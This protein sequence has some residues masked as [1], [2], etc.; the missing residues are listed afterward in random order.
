MV[1]GQWSVV[2]GQWS[3]VSGQCECL[4]TNNVLIEEILLFI[5]HHSL[6]TIH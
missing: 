1:S 4:L 2:S 3:V 5:N 6:L